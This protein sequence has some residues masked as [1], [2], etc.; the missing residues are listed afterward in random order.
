MDPVSN[1]GP[2]RGLE[3]IPGASDVG[4]ADS[5]SGFTDAL[6]EAVQT[7][8]E[9]QHESEASQLA[10]AREEDID[11]HDVLIKVEEAEIA[12]KTMMQIRN[13]LV[14]AYQEVMR[15]GS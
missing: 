12:F 10:F 14:E 13:K 1:I 2:I 15:M 5:G 6:K 7:V 8:D 4:R 9:L 3:E 11:L